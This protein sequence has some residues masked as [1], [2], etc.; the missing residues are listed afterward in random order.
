[1][2]KRYCLEPIRGIGMRTWVAILVLLVS[3]WTPAQA[4][5]AVPEFFVDAVGTRS[6]GVT[7][8]TRVDVY[9]RIPFERMT[10]RSSV[11]GFTAEYEVTV[12]ALA[13]E[14]DRLTS[15]PVQSRIWD[16][17]VRVPTFADTRRPESAAVTTQSLSLDPGTYQLSVQ[18]LDQSSGESFVRDIPV[19]VRDLNRSH[20]LSDI[21]LLESYDPE[22][23]SIVPR[24]DNV[25]GTEEGGFELFFEVFAS[26]PR[27]VRL[28]HEIVRI[29]KDA[30][31]LPTVTELS[32]VQEGE[33]V[34]ERS[35][36]TALAA[37]R[38]QHVIT[39]PVDEL[40]VGTYVA[41][42]LLED[43]DGTVLDETQ[44]TLQ[45]RWM[46]LSAHI[47]DIDLAIDQLE[48]IA[49]GKDLKYIRSASTLAERYDR[50][51]A[52]WDKRD[53]TPGTLRNESMEEY[54]YRV[55]YANRRY[56]SVTDG[57]KTD[58]GFVLVKF[59]EPDHV[60]RRPHSFDYQPYEVWVYQRMG[61]QYI[62]VDKTGFGDY[63][64][65]VPVWDERTRLF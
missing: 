39:V 55:N 1:M 16:G 48:Y 4:Q 41:R 28:H 44:R 32:D 29:R 50:F 8:Q 11:D 61:R 65:L 12:E 22:T 46:G 38:S 24:A 63:Q 13:R 60:E 43:R 35:D 9:L 23:L 58:R 31:V 25:V 57:W 49:G 52:F 54:Y 33:V 15:T 30:A 34:E 45:V 21:T 27:E 10:F 19:R 6:A 36:L 7:H 64:L 17:T 59:G 20:V 37:G 62:F 51:R 5:D 40:K 26:T 53:P 42:V 56:S 3:G 47:Q 2:S 18:V 14:G